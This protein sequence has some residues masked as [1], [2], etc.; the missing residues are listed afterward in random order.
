MLNIDNIFRYE[1][2]FLLHIT[3][4]NKTDLPY[5]WPIDLIRILNNFKCPCSHVENIQV[6]K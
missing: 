2:Q 4:K 5:P 6:T 3:V 1:R